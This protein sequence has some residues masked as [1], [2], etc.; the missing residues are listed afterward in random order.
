MLESKEGEG[1]EGGM[2]VGDGLSQQS[3]NGTRLI[4]LICTRCHVGV[5]EGDLA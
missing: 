5:R 2:V 4:K 1:K 3:S